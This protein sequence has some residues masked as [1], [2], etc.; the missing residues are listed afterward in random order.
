MTDA[1]KQKASLAHMQA[2]AV[3]FADPEKAGHAAQLEV[4][5]VDDAW[6]SI[7]KHHMFCINYPATWLADLWLWLSVRCW[8]MGKA[9]REDLPDPR[10][11]LPGEVKLDV[12][13]QVGSVQKGQWSP[14]QAAVIRKALAGEMPMTLWNLQ[15]GWRATLLQRQDAENP[16]KGKVLVEE[17]GQV[18]TTERGEPPKPG[19][20]PEGSAI[21]AGEP[22]K[23]K[24][25]LKV[26]IKKPKPRKKK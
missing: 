4:E 5:T 18:R 3:V 25:K 6:V 26:K 15:N 11:G 7:S 23:R 12:M 22:P 19:E 20:A 16:D 17:D 14:A 21:V 8:K 2:A 9:A 24:K 1:E 10:E 13:D